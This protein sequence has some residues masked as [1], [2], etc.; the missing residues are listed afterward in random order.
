MNDAEPRD[1]DALYQ[2]WRAKHICDRCDGTRRVKTKLGFSMNCPVCVPK[3][4]VSV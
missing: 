2:E 1:H 3:A 4:G